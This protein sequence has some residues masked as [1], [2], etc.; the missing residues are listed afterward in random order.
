M[1]LIGVKVAC[2]VEEPDREGEGVLLGTSSVRCCRCLH[3][4]D[5]GP[6]ERGSLA[7]R[8]RLNQTV[9]TL[10]SWSGQ[11]RP[12]VPIETVCWLSLSRHP[13]CSAVLLQRCVWASSLCDREARAFFR[14]IPSCRGCELQ[15]LTT[16]A[17]SHLTRINSSKVGQ[18][19]V[20]QGQ[21]SGPAS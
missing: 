8:R 4:S 5:G 17:A 2:Y 10:A 19:R 1:A 20:N 16:G 3:S 9:L 21:G 14:R 13:L 7:R 15:L 11:R 12:L 6:C 18:G